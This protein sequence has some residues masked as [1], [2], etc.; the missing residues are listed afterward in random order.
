M[1]T[2]PRGNAA[3]EDEEGGA[4]FLAE[5]KEAQIL[6]MAG[7]T[8]E[9]EA[10]VARGEGEPYLPG[11]ERDT[12]SAAPT[13]PESGSSEAKSSAE[14]KYLLVYS[15]RRL[16]ACLH[17]WGARAGT[18]GPR[19]TRGAGRPCRRRGNTPPCASSAGEAQR[20]REETRPR[21]RRAPRAPSRA[22]RNLRRRRG[23]ARQVLLR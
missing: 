21:R 13:P 19:R 12:A 14:A 4:P 11:G 8:E 23:G 10:S 15:G 16:K 7:A 5:I 17:R 20:P 9:A 18:S 1:L 2:T 6:A 22:P 3:E